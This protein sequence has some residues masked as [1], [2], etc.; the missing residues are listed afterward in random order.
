MFRMVRRTDFFPAMFAAIHMPPV[1]PHPDSGRYDVFLNLLFNF[2][3][4]SQGVMALWAFRKGFINDFVN[5][6][7]YLPGHPNM[8]RFLPWTFL[9]LL[10][11]IRLRKFLHPL[12]LL[13]L[14][15]FLQLANFIL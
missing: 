13:G 5:V 4:F 15:L 10:C 3:G 11:R 2:N 7:R 12:L 14:D 6:I 1:F 8:P 9:A